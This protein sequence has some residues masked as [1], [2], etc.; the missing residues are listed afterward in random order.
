MAENV[1]FRDIDSCNAVKVPP[2]SKFIALSSMGRIDGKLGGIKREIHH[3][4][5]SRSDI[6]HI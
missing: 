2:R 3:I 5:I 4:W 6:Y 1:K